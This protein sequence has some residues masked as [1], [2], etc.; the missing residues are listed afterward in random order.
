MIYKET[1]IFKSPSVK[2]AFKATNIIFQ[3]LTRKPQNNPAGIYRIKCN[4]CRRWYVG[5]TGHDIATRRKEHTRYIKNNNLV[6]AYAMHTLH[7][8]HEYSPGSSILKL[9]NQ[10]P[11][12]NIMNIWDATYLQA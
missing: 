8:R 4:M 9:L 6:S 10:C 3:Q 11:K 7:N 12:G 1:N 5:Q 2:V